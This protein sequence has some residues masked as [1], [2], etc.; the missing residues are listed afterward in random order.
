MEKEEYPVDRIRRNVQDVGNE[1]TVQE[2]VELKEEI[3]RNNDECF[4]IID[5]NIKATMQKRRITLVSM[6][7]TRIVFNFDRLKYLLT[8]NYRE[9]DET[10][11]LITK[12][13]KDIIELRKDKET[14]KAIKD[15]V[16]LHKEYDIT[17]CIPQYQ[18][19]LQ[20]VY[21]KSINLDDYFNQILEI[22]SL[23]VRGISMIPANEIAD[24]TD[25]YNKE[26]DEN[27]LKLGLRRKE[28]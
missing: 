28:K 2:L 24:E 17:K 7:L 16:K 12:L 21:D 5:D 18:L 11:F 13:K 25:T 1:L 15:A 4:G 23:R 10:K 26:I 8:F 27:L 9:G 6:Y 19:I 3:Y 20:L 14:I 22:S